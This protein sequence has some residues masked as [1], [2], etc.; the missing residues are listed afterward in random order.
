MRFSLGVDELLRVELLKWKRYTEET[1]FWRGATRAP[2][3]GA[4]LTGRQFSKSP[5]S[6]QRQ[7]KTKRRAV[8]EV[9]DAQ[10]TIVLLQHQFK[11]KLGS[12]FLLF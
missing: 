6:A 5:N 12:F 10:A 8:F 2:K 1:D 7:S 3:A 11:S 9:R 4:A